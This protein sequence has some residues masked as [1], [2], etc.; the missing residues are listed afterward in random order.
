MGC[1]SFCAV[2]SFCVLNIP[3]NENTIFW[4]GFSLLLCYLRIAFPNTFSLWPTAF[5]SL[6][7]FSV[8][9]KK[10]TRPTIISLP[11]ISE[12]SCSELSVDAVAVRAADLWWTTFEFSSSRLPRFMPSLYYMFYMPLWS[13]W[14]GCAVW[15]VCIGIAA[16]RFDW[17]VAFKS[18]QPADDSAVG[19]SEHF[20]LSEC[21]LAVFLLATRMHFFWWNFGLWLE[22]H[23]ID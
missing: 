18:K 23:L 21:L 2:F 20:L 8:L 4:K 6:W 19:N 11:H 13:T 14:C 10:K 3:K 7:W 5:F 17:L 9:C 12:C 22:I 16:R 1:C 15:C